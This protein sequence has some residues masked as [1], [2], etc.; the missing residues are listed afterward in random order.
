MRSP[1]IQPKPYAYHPADFKLLQPLGNKTQRKIGQVF[2]VEHR[3][4][5]FKAVMKRLD[6]NVKNRHLV[7]VLLNEALFDFKHPSLPETLVVEETP[8][9]VVLIKSYI[10]GENL[11][12]FWKK[13]RRKERIPF[14]KKLIEQLKV[15]FA[16]LN[17]KG[18][19]H[20]D[21]KPSNIQISGDKD[22]FTVALIDFGMAFYSEN[23]PERKLI[24]SLGYSPPELILGYL[25][26]A[27]HSSD[28]FALGIC[29]YQLFTR[30]LPLSHPNPAVM[31]NLQLTHPIQNHPDLPRS[32]E[33]FIKKCC[34]K[35]SFSK[36]P[37]YLTTTEVELILQEGILGRGQSLEELSELIPNTKTRDSWFRGLIKIF[38]KTNIE[39]K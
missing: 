6:L 27:R 39:I 36:P 29:I 12:L 2:L 1:S 33:Q 8:T 34:Y 9:Q 24:F 37:S 16:I 13:L 20:G 4:L 31:T 38:S 15:P 22:H 28:L 7:S 19:I 21:I 14:V 17:E 23:P 18:I 32:L 26:L 30:T 11:D 10:V 35:A 3:S 5:G 25:H